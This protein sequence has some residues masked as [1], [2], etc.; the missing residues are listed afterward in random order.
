MPAFQPFCRVGDEKPAVSSFVVGQFPSAYVI[1]HYLRL[2]EPQVQSPR[3]TA[4][5]STDFL[6][7]V[8]PSQKTAKRTRQYIS[9]S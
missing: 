9:Y 1:T 6:G 4:F 2:T 7:F 8:R 3:L 5:D